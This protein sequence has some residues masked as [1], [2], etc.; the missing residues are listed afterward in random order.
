[1]SSTTPPRVQEE[2]KAAHAA[3]WQARSDQKMK[4]LT[5]QRRLEALNARREAD[6]HARRQK[7]AQLLYHEDLAFRAEL[8]RGKETPEQRR[9]KLAAR[10]RELAARRETERQQLAAQL[11]DRAFQE[12]CDVLRDTDSK[13]VLYRTMEERNAQVRPHVR[14]AARA[15]ASTRSLGRVGRRR[16]VLQCPAAGRAQRTICRRADDDGGVGRTMLPTA[17]RLGAD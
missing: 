16:A 1:M 15:A 3:H 2:R 5:V 9:A 17:P 14:P 4:S 8:V 12:N 11:Y 7:L 6:L 10:A 13:R